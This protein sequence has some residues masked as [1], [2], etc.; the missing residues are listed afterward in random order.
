MGTENKIRGKQEE[1]GKSSIY[2]MEETG[3]LYADGIDK[4][5]DIKIGK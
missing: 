3:I 2:E 1:V 5:T 4:E